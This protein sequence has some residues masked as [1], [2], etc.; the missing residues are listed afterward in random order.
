MFKI[1]F[2]F[3][4]NILESTKNVYTVMI[5]FKTREAFTSHPTQTNKT[6]I[7]F[8]AQHVFQMTLT[9]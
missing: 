7:H 1:H 8:K 4:M 5:C 2:D 3:M 9:K 6:I